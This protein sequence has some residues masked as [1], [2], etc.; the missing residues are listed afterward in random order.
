MRKGFFTTFLLCLLSSPVFAANGYVPKQFSNVSTGEGLYP[1]SMNNRRQEI[2][3]TTKNNVSGINSS[4]QM[5][6]SSKRNVIKR[7]VKARA[8]TTT[9]TTTQYSDTNRRVIPRSVNARSSINTQNYNTYNTTNRGVT[10]RSANKNTVLRVSNSRRETRNTTSSGTAVSSSKCFANYKECM[11]TYCKREDTPYNRCYCSAKLAQIDSKY[12]KNIDN[13]IQQII[14]LQNTTTTE[15]DEDLVPLETFWTENIAQYTGSNA[16]KNLD[17]ALNIDWPDNETRFQGQNAFNIGH[18]Y[19]VNYLHACSYMASNLRD[20]YKSE[21]TRDCATYEE[22][23]QKIQN[24]AESLI[25]N[26]KK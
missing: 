10:A 2:T 21:I 26:Y 15:S 14:V 24:V 20:A 8:S 3:N 6:S 5:Q 16:W 19:C 18:Q 23:L 22:T 11:E 13:L 12:Q 17:E 25:E 4:T 7:P 9:L 1:Y